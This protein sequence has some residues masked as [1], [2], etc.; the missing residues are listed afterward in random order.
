MEKRLAKVVVKTLE[1]ENV[2]SSYSDAITK[3]WDDSK[4]GLN[5]VVEEILNKIDLHLENLNTIIETNNPKTIED[6]IALNR[7]LED[8]FGHLPWEGS[9]KPVLST[10][11]VK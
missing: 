4:T 2:I 1:K 10:G 9:E 7:D 5:E 11:D 3:F 6:M 8:F